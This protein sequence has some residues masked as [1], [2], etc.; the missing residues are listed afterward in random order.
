MLKPKK[1]IARKEIHRPIFMLN[2]EAKILIKIL[3]NGVQQCVKR[4]LSLHQVGLIPETHSVNVHHPVNR[5][6]KKD[7]TVIPID[8]ESAFD[9]IRNIIDDKNSQQ[10]AEKGIFSTR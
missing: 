5:L 6:K 10:T 1:G 8:T 3:A 7:H 4:T 2:R 9:K